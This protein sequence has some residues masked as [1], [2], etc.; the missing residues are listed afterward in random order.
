MIVAVPVCKIYCGTY[1]FYDKTTKNEHVRYEGLWGLFFYEKNKKK[2]I[3]FAFK[4]IA[5][6][7]AFYIFL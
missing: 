2:Q 3:I 1:L 4:I 5:I 6:M 7:R